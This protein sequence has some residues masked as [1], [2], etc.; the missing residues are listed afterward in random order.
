[1]GRY[2][3]FNYNKDGIKGK[4]KNY[5][6]RSRIIRSKIREEYNFEKLDFSGVNLERRILE[7]LKIQ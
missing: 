5:S 3:K 2:Y 6:R 4:N 7:K 1:M